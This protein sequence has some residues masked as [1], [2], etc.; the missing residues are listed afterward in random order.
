[1]KAR[2]CKCTAGS[3]MGAPA[4]CKENTTHH[5]GYCRECRYRC[6]DLQRCSIDHSK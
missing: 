4:R 5:S 6:C 2:R 1:M 3:K